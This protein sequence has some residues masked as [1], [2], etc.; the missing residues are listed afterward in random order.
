MTNPKQIQAYA[1]EL[2]AIY[3]KIDNLNIEAKD[4]LA[5]AKDAGVNVKALSKAAKEINMDAEKRAKK[6]ED[7]H[8]LEMFREVLKLTEPARILEAAE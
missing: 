1:P 3:A 7:E 4:F 2:A 6:Y 5:S 8:Q